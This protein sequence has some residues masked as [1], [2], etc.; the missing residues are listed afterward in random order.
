MISTMKVKGRPFKTSTAFKCPICDKTFPT[1]TDHSEHIINDHE[2]DSRCLCL[3]LH[4][5]SLKV[6]NTSILLTK[7]QII[8][9]FDICDFKTSLNIKL[10]KHKQ[11]K[12]PVDQT[13]TNRQPPN[14][15][16]CNYSS[17]GNTDLIT[18]T[19]STHLR[20]DP[21]QNNQALSHL[22]EEQI[23]DVLGVVHDNVLGDI[24]GDVHVQGGDLLREGKAALHQTHHR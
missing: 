19:Q 1:K 14:C 13:H 16:L 23:G 18:H 8:F 11:S 22:L 20:L 10:L 3:E 24:L 15:D 21:S 2:K 12:H 6:E 17:T 5:D 9:K 4:P 7:D